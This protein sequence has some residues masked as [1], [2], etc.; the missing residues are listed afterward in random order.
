DAGVAAGGID[1]GLVPRQASVGNRIANH[2][3]RGPVFDRAAGIA[4]FAFPPQLDAGQVA[5]EQR[6]PYERGVPDVIAD[7][8]DA[9]E[10]AHGM[11]SLPAAAAW[12][13]R[14]SFLMAST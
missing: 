8:V 4:P 1:D 6:Q 10:R 14:S 3:Q 2:L 13:M 11:R 9:G 7:G 5:L 12:P